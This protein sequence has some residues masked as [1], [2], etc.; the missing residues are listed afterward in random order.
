M[1]TRPRL[2]S[3]SIFQREPVT[4]LAQDMSDWGVFSL[5]VGEAGRVLRQGRRGVRDG[6][7]GAGKPRPI[8]RFCRSAC[9]D[10]RRRGIH[11]AMRRCVARPLRPGLA[12]ALASAFGADAGS[13]ARWALASDE[14][15]S[16]AGRQP[17]RPVGRSA[18]APWPFAAA[19]ARCV[20]WPLRHLRSGPPEDP[21]RPRLADDM[22]AGRSKFC[23]GLSGDSH[24]DNPNFREPLL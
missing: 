11:S 15:W 21:M 16:E 8:G 6:C 13:A 18:L 17:W 5:G 1:V 24:G 23:M 14:T 19:Q 12:T 3:I 2:S 22:A 7:K 4:V 10:W 20:S 9:A